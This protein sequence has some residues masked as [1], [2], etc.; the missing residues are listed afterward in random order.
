[1]VVVAGVYALPGGVST[2]IPPRFSSSYL[3]F[4]WLAAAAG[5]AGVAGIKFTTLFCCNSPSRSGTS[6]YIAIRPRLPP[7]GY[8]EADKTQAIAASL[9][10]RSAESW[11]MPALTRQQKIT[12]RTFGS[13]ISSRGS[14][15]GLAVTGA[16]TCARILAGRRSG[17]TRDDFPVSTAYFDLAAS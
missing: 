12:F 17:P 10:A 8:A 6:F 16:P 2:W 7:A 5:T 13:P 14:P 4:C 3:S 9:D 11:A 1:M 15:A